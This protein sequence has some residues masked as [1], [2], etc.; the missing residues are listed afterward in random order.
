M[1]VVKLASLRQRFVDQSQSLNLFFAADEDPAWI[2]KVHAEAFH[3]PYIKSLYYIYTQA[4][5][6]ASKEVVCEACQ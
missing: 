4:G 3:D 2:A 1:T 5:V 6:M